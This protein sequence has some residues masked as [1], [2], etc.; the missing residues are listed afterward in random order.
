MILHLSSCLVLSCL[1]GLPGR[2]SL[3][4]LDLQ[5][6]ALDGHGVRR[7]AVGVHCKLIIVCAVDEGAD[8]RLLVG[9]LRLKRRNV[10][11]VGVLNDL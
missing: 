4:P 6:A 9:R 3:Y 5:F 7:P 11:F 1:G 10:V 2:L 8:K